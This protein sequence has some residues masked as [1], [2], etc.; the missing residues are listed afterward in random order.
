MMSLILFYLERARVANLWVLCRY[1]KKFVIFGCIQNA[2]DTI[3]KIFT[4]TFSL[5]SI[6][7]NQIKVSIRS[8]SHNQVLHRYLGTINSMHFTMKNPAKVIL[9]VSCYFA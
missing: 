4:F 9:N 6:I 2:I 7:L 5:D 1:I 3:N 8:N